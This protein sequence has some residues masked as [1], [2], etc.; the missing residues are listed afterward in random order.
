MDITAKYRTKYPPKEHEEAVR[1]L[2]EGITNKQLQKDGHFEDMSPRTTRRETR[3]EHNQKNDNYDQQ[4]LSSANSSSTQDVTSTTIVNS[5]LIC[6]K[7]TSTS[8]SAS[9]NSIEAAYKEPIPSR[10]I[11]VQCD[12]KSSSLKRDNLFDASMQASSISSTKYGFYNFSPETLELRRNLMQESV[13]SRDNVSSSKGKISEELNNSH[14]EA[15][16]SMSELSSSPAMSDNEAENES[17]HS[18]YIQEVTKPIKQQHRQISSAYDSS[19]ADS[20]P[21]IEPVNQANL[22]R[23]TT[24][25]RNKNVDKYINEKQENNLT[26]RARINSL[27]RRP[28]TALSYVSTNKLRDQNQPLLNR[29]SG[30]GSDSEFVERPI[31]NRAISQQALTT[32]TTS[33]SSS[34]SNS[35]GNNNGN[36]NASKPYIAGALN[37]E[38]VDTEPSC[39][40]SDSEFG[41]NRL[42]QDTTRFAD[43]GSINQ[44]FQGDRTD[45]MLIMKNGYSMQ[46][47]PAKPRLVSS[48]HDEQVRDYKTL[49]RLLST[50]QTVQQQQQQK[51]Q[52]QTN[53]NNNNSINNNNISN[54]SNN[55]YYD[56]DDLDNNNRVQDFKLKQ[57]VQQEVGMKRL[58]RTKSRGDLERC[59]GENCTLDS[60]FN[61]NQLKKSLSSKA[62]QYLPMMDQEQRFNGDGR[63]LNNR[64][65][66]M[67]LSR[68]Y[69][70]HS[71][72]QQQQQLQY[73]NDRYVGSSGNQV[74][75]ALINGYLTSSRRP[76]TS[77]RDDK[78]NSQTLLTKPSLYTPKVETMAAA[79]APTSKSARQQ[80]SQH[81]TTSDVFRTTSMRQVNNNRIYCKDRYDENGV[82]NQ[83]FTSQCSNDQSNFE[84]TYL[85]EELPVSGDGLNSRRLNESDDSESP[86]TRTW[87]NPNLRATLKAEDGRR[88]LSPSRKSS[89]S[90]SMRDVNNVNGLETAILDAKQSYVGTRNPESSPYN[91]S[92]ESSAL[93]VSPRFVRSHQLDYDS[94]QRLNESGLPKVNPLTTTAASRPRELSPYNGLTRG[95][96]NV[97]GLYTSGGSPQIRGRAMSQQSL[98]RPTMPLSSGRRRG[99]SNSGSDVGGSSMSLVSRLHGRY[100]NAHT[101]SPVVMYIPPTVPKSSS[102]L[103]EPSTSIVKSSNLRKSSRSRQKSSSQDRSRK[104]FSRNGSDSES[105]SL[106]KTL[107]K[108]RSRQGNYSSKRI[109]RGHNGLFDDDDEENMDGVGQLASELDTYKF[110]R[111]Y[112]VPK[113]AKINWFAKLKQ[114]VSS[115]SK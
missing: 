54:T 112:S 48:S 29:S 95:T 18:K 36:S 96:T 6:S 4:S 101:R 100:E 80:V 77:S 63:D 15:P 52:Q 50:R 102:L 31:K 68:R 78:A 40:N 34:N 47:K 3:N 2:L 84:R 22:R 24:I 46:V 17:Q 86:S 38:L 85:T 32:T 111:R 35:Y 93:E 87:A 7:A 33:S 67:S 64:L 113:D 60:S 69:P 82:L 37:D 26:A 106:F 71:F 115:G 114:R 12:L 99:G 107:V 83:G 92:T 70:K 98:T 109:G 76:H 103:G 94:Q 110:R 30:L 61:G 79:A 23:K 51:R 21:K 8:D 104:S 9:I 57:P 20:A 66:S 75:Q 41:E 13:T 62:D 11:A 105:S 91:S 39:F 88:L 49:E 1:M 56:D 25:D 19:S 14:I 97:Q 42:L 44:D 65:N 90:Y 28:K 16:T 53:I 72:Q 108:P 73:A 89:R 45:E 5:N 27:P 58:T 81:N 74:N 43:K 59:F 55:V 10:T